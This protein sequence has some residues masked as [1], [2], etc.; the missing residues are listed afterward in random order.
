MTNNGIVIGGVLA[1]IGVIF[2]V[3]VLLNSVSENSEVSKGHSEQQ[4]QLNLLLKTKNA[5]GKFAEMENLALQILKSVPHDLAAYHALAKVS[6]MNQDIT[7]LKLIVMAGM[8]A[9]L[10]HNRYDYMPILEIRNTFE[11]LRI[12]IFDQSYLRVG[13]RQNL[14]FQNCDGKTIKFELSDVSSNLRFPVE[15]LK[16]ISSTP[17]LIN[18]NDF[19]KL[20]E[21]KF[22]IRIF[23]EID[24]ISNNITP[25]SSARISRSTEDKSNVVPFGT[26]NLNLEKS[27][28]LKNEGVALF[29]LRKEGSH[30]HTYHT[31][32]D[33]KVSLHL[34]AGRYYL[35][36]AGILRKTFFMIAETQFKISIE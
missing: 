20:P 11:K 18:Y 22:Q 31:D 36:V 10:D 6:I 28:V 25:K 29:Q 15:F 35:H 9:E 4:S 27:L 24:R 2:T 30:W 1:T 21:S 3:F 5:C 19:M 33:N 7:A 23:E 26:L 17:G 34:P 13:N 8:Y 16:K 12:E 32:Q 14:N